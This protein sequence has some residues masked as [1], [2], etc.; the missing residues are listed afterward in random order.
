MIF[1]VEYITVTYLDKQSKAVAYVCIRCIGE[2]T[3]EL[4]A[5]HSV[6]AAVIQSQ[7]TGV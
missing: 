7:Q 1:N 2:S 5:T 3:P 4:A 6:T